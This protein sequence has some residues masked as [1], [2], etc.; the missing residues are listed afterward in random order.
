[1]SALAIVTG[2]SGWLGQRLLRALSQGLVGLPALTQAGDRSIRCLVQKAEEEQRIG[3]AAASAQCIRGDLTRGESLAELF[4]DAPGATVFHC[5][6]II[7]PNRVRDFYRVNVEGTRALLEA[8]IEG[9]ARRFIHVSSNSP[10]GCNPSPEHRFDE[11]SPYAPYMNY[12]RSKRQAEELVRA[13]GANEALECVI[14]RPPWFYGP[15]QPKRMSTFFSMIRKGRTPLPG[16]G[17]NVRSMAFV[18]NI[19]Q[20]LLLCETSRRAIGQ[21]YWIADRRPYTMREIVDTVADLLEVDFE[22]DVKRGALVL[23]GA[24]SELS[25]LADRILQAVG[26]YNQEIHVLSE[27]NKNIAC[28]IEKA[29]REL[30][31]APQVE[32]RDGMRLAIQDLLS[33]G[34]TL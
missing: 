34:Q 16:G 19:C 6:G 4:R 23:P 32:L 20:G 15:G 31:Y 7:H 2:G 11:N 17:S 26:L 3:D 28:S 10:I 29:E 14:V 8:A 12:G 27:M 21:T 9:G 24:V 18:D 22:M 33:R 30:G 13:A 25:L 1:M 5:A